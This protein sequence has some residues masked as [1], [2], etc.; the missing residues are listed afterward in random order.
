M[1]LSRLGE[2]INV[3]GSLANVAQ[4]PQHELANLRNRDIVINNVIKHASYGLEAT[5]CYFI[6]TLVNILN[7]CL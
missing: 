2:I 1:E 6:C 4:V 3:V 5:I 7:L